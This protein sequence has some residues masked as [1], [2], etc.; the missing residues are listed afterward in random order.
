MI[1][2]IKKARSVS[3]ETKVNAVVNYFRNV[4][5]LIF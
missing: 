2:I 1:Q 3:D 4:F 5:R